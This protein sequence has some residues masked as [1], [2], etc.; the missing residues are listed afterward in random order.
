MATNPQSMPLVNRAVVD[1][2][3]YN[4]PANAN[5]A[6]VVTMAAVS[7]GRNVISEIRCSFNIAPAANTNLTIASGGATV[8]D[9]DVMTTNTDTYKVITFN[10]PLKGSAINA[11]M[12]VTIAAGGANCKGKLNVVGWSEPALP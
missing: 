9:L 8:F 7:D 4:A 6:S 2:A 3:L 12:V 1:A 11:N 5:T 10:P